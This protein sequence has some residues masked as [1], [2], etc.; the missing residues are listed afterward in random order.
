MEGTRKIVEQTAHDIRGL[1]ETSLENYLD[2]DF[3]GELDEAEATLKEAKS[4]MK[5]YLSRGNQNKNNDDVNPIM[6]PEAMQVG[7]EDYARRL[8]AGDIKGTQLELGLYY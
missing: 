1:R 7:A 4:T 8:K 5:E 2:S 6:L 3:K